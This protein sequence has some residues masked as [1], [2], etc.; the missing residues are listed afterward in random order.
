MKRLTWLVAV[1]SIAVVAVH[2]ESGY[3]RPIFSRENQQP[4]LHA[5]EMGVL[6]EYHR[7]DE[8]GGRA[9]LDWKRNVLTFTPYARYGL[10]ENL[11]AFA[12]LPFVSVDS[13]RFG[14]HT[15]FGDVSFGLEL[16]AFEYVFGYPHAYPYII[17]YVE[18]ILP[19]GNEDK[20][21]GRGKTDAVFGASAGTTVAKVYHYVL[22]ARYNVNYQEDD[23]GIFSLASALIWDLNS[24]F[25][26]LVEA[27]G[28][29]E[30]T[31]EN[32]IPFY[33][34]GGMFYRASDRLMLSWYGGT[35]INTDEDGMGA[36]KIGYLF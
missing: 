18:I 4:D 20:K 8:S 22:D 24:R 12:N 13:D 17:P 23:K 3:N 9:G 28:T 7:Y 32:R 29:S 14:K 34:R 27:K 1:I 16:L 6:S 35:A 36:L 33:F 11:T 15:G 19:T 5:L 2:A 10:H 26:I 25:S 30:E 31:E 21:L